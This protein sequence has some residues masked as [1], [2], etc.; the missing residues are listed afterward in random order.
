M[1]KEINQRPDSGP[2]S[3][4]SVCHR[5]LDFRIE[6]PTNV[7]QR[8]SRAINSAVSWDHTEDVEQDRL[9]RAQALFQMA[10]CS[11]RLTVGL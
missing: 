10:C 9:S 2:P 3:D 11:I 7:Q 1:Q 5:S 4:M 6:P 8:P